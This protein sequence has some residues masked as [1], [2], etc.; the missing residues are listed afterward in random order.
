MKL[1]VSLVILTFLTLFSFFWGYKNYQKF[2]ICQ[3]ANQDLMKSLR[4]VGSAQMKKTS[5]EKGEAL[6]FPINIAILN[7]EPES[8]SE[9]GTYLLI[10]INSACSACLETALEIYAAVKEYENSGLI[11]LSLSR[12]TPE[13]LQRL[14]LEKE[15]P[16]KLA[17][18][19]QGQL[20]RLFNITG[21]PAIILLHQGKVQVK[22]D[23]LS[24]D[25]QLPRL[26]DLLNQFL[27]NRKNDKTTD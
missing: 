14:I 7:G 12:E 15:W 6:P 23:A 10:F 16:I 3:K 11:L 2:I 22:A 13:E 24:I 8:F 21:V 26:K 1:K 9:N 25:A 4:E 17:H 5:F 18:D 19:E 20:H 27:E